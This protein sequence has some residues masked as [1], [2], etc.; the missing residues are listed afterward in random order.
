MKGKSREPTQLCRIL[1]PGRE[2]HLGLAEASP[3]AVSEIK[4]SIGAQPRSEV[5]GKHDAGSGANET[6]DGLT[7]A[8][9]ALRSAAEDA[10]SGQPSDIN[11]DIPVFDRADAPPRCRRTGQSS[12]LSFWNFGL[13]L[14]P[15]LLIAALRFAFLYPNPERALSDTLLP[16]WTRRRRLKCAAHISL[17]NRGSGRR[18]ALGRIWCGSTFRSWNEKL[19]RHT[20]RHR[21]NKSERWQQYRCLSLWSFHGG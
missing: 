17:P 8:E 18:L 10:P 11:E 4:K 1:P 15:V 16:G 13:C 14:S 6:I 3:L 20:H 2:D 21:S 7:D 5:A 19:N 9:K 12:S